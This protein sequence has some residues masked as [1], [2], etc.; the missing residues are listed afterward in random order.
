MRLFNFQ[1]QQNE[2]LEKELEAARSEIKLNATRL[3]AFQNAFNSINDE[4]ESDED[5][6]DNYG[7]EDDAEEDDDDSNDYDQ[8]IP[9][10]IES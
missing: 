2:I 1:E 10:S 8:N 6:E 7:F 3:D 4:I 9:L 5:M